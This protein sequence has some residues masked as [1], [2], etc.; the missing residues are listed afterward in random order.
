MKDVEVEVT[1]NIAT[2]QSFSLNLKY[3]EV[4]IE[5]LPPATVCHEHRYQHS[6]ALATGETHSHSEEHSHPHASND[7]EGLE[8]LVVEPIFNATP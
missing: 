6:H 1:E 8:G 7:P 4:A 2:Q 3:P 5:R